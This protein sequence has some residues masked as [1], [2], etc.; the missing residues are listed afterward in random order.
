MTK[1]FRDRLLTIKESSDVESVDQWE[2]E[3]KSLVE[4]LDK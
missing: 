4:V 1:T 2:E 3:W